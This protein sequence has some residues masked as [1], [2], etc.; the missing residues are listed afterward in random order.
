MTNLDQLRR[1]TAEMYQHTPPPRG[2]YDMIEFII[3]VCAFGLFKALIGYIIFEG[4][5]HHGK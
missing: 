5:D 1:L 3:A 4:G 2:A